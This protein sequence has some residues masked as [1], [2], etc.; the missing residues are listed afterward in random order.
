MNKIRN[1]LFIMADQLRADMLSCYRGGQGRL[2]TPHIDALAAAGTLFDNCYVQG[3]VCGPSRMSTYTGRYV[4]SHGAT[5]NFVPLAA[6]LLTMGDHLRQAGLR[7]AVVGKTHIVGDRAGMARLGLDPKSKEGLLVDQGGFEPYARDDGVLPESKLRHGDTPY[8]QYLKAQGY[9]ARNA[10]HDY[11]NAGAG[12]DGEVL[13]GWQ[14][15]HASLPARVQERHSETA[16]TTDRAIDFMREQGDAPWCLHLSYIKPHWPYIAPA[17]YHAMF[18][19]DDAPAAVRSD[20]EREAAHPVLQ[21]FRQHPEGLAFS[22]EEVRRAVVPAYMGLVKQLDDHLGRLLQAVDQLGRRDDTLIVLTADHGDL[23]GDHWLGEKEMFYEASVRVPLIVVDPTLSERVPVCDA[24]VQAIDLLPTFKDAV[25]LPCDD[26]WLEGRSLLPLLRGEAE[27][28]REAVFSELDYAFYGARQQ[29]GVDV[30]E[31]RATM[32]R[33]RRWK[34]VRYE[35]FAPQL[36]DLAQDPDELQDLG[37][38]DSH[39][40]VRAEMEARIARWRAGCRNRVTMSDAEVLARGDRSKV[41]G[42]RIGEW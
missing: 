13:S 6:H 2:Q 3:T 31:A 35:G 28:E 26:P 24:L 30:N 9:D 5:W 32:V 4:A 27:Q 20:A 16:W 37:L 34:Y 38:A 19:A 33:T 23:L 10:W 18:G 22:R 21:A 14:M 40:E 25:G 15:R 11:A 36:F 12:P 29:L 17:P 1:V 8:N 42:V 7:V 41:G 39:A